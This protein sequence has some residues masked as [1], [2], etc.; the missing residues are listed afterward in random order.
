MKG[1]IIVRSVSQGAFGGFFYASADLFW[2]GTTLT[3][4]NVLYQSYNVVALSGANGTPFTATG[5]NLQMQ[6]NNS[7][8]L[9]P[10]F[11]TD[12]IFKGEFYN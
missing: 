1:R 2:N 10:T 8:T 5:G 3:V 7:G 6:F 12:V 4:S 11:I 9:T